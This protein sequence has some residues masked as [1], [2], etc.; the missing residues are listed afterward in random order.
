MVGWLR[1]LDG[2]LRTPKHSRALPD[3]GTPGARWAF[4]E[5]LHG[6]A[7]APPAGDGLASVVI[8]AP[9]ADAASTPS[10]TTE[11]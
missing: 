5:Q 7:P 1:R 2:R 4:A 11:R 6:V 3:A 9:R 10:V 8:H